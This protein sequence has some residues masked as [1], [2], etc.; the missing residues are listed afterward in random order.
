MFHPVT[1]TSAQLAG[2]IAVRRTGNCCVLLA[3]RDKDCYAC[4]ILQ[5]NGTAVDMCRVLLSDLF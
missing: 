2:V 5:V 4:N 3:K 1:H